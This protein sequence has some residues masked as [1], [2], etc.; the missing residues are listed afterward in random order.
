MNQFVTSDWHLGHEKSIV[1]DKRPFT[2]LNHMHE[3]LVNNYNASV[4]PNDICYFLGDIGFRD[5]GYEIIPKLNGK[6][7]CVLGNHDKGK[8]KMYEMGFDL[9]VN[10]I[11]TTIGQSIITMTH[12]PIRGVYREG[13]E[14]QDGETM[15]NFRPFE[16]WH[17][18]SRHDEYSIPDFD[19]FHL[20]GHTHKRKGNDI[21][22]G[23]QWDIGVVGNNY[24]PVSFKEIE[25]W[26]AKYN[27]LEKK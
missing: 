10:G 14:N 9:V 23:K 22:S 4:R 27:N 2:D 21:I 16:G 12:C 1:Y 17:G 7:I 3:V 6:K 26:I 20:H 19:Q 11:M 15:K 18:E 13:P 24:R 5:A 8:S 25:S